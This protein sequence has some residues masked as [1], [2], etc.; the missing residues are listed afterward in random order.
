MAIS[1]RTFTT[2]SILRRDGSATPVV[3]RR[4]GDGTLRFDRASGVSRYTGAQNAW[5]H[6]LLDILEGPALPDISPRK[7]WRAKALA[8]Y[9]SGENAGWVEAMVSGSLE[10]GPALTLGDGATR[11]VAVQV[12]GGVNPYIL[13]FTESDFNNLTATVSFSTDSTD[14]VNGTWT[15]P[16]DLDAWHW[17]VTAGAPGANTQKIDIP[18][19]AHPRWV[20]VAVTAGNTAGDGCN[21]THWQLHQL[22]AEG[23]LDYWVIVG[24]SLSEQTG[25]AAQLYGKIRAQFPDRDPLIFNRATSG[26]KVADTLGKI[27]DILAEHP[28]ASY[29]ILCIGTNNVS[30]TRA[31]TG[32]LEANVTSVVEGIEDI[33]EAI[34]AAGKEVILGNIPFSNY[35]TGVRPFHGRNPM[36]GSFVWN[37]DGVEA[38]RAQFSPRFN[39][40]LYTNS[41]RN[42][43][44]ISTDG[45][46]WVQTYGHGKWQ[47]FMVEQCFAPVY[48]GAPLAQ[49]PARRKHAVIPYSSA[50]VTM[51]HYAKDNKSGNSGTVAVK[52]V[53]GEPTGWSIVTTN[54]FTGAISTGT[55]TGNN[56]GIFID[57]I[58]KYG[59]MATTADPGQVQLSGLDP[60][61]RY[62]IKILGSEK[63]ASDT[64]VGAYTVTGGTVSGAAYT[65]TVL[66]DCA[67]NTTQTADFDAVPPTVDGKITISV[68]CD[69]ASSSTHCYLNAIEVIEL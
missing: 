41:M 43:N 5:A 16:E 10:I 60:S 65:K 14:G 19:A 8:A 17:P 11:T 26:D 56:S 69:A 54:T 30:H 52:T 57:E 31:V 45:V 9:D 46:H 7:G 25:N 48:T 59:L 53:E 40:D 21:L 1:P 24:D 33:C 61:K 15:T 38:L 32:P 36:A 29:V 23:V 37:R 44:F 62:C 49:V 66:L 2:T 55:E 34:V 39:W 67:D 18:A 63:T 27:D 28:R 51:T 64:H 58:L 22:P 4:Y 42:Q 20:R 13:S 6:E 50:G 47:D 3:V 68:E 35:T 12:A